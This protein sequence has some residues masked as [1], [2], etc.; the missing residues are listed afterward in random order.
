LVFSFVLD[1]GP[2][3]SIMEVSMW[4]QLQISQVFSRYWSDNSTS[5]TISYSKEEAKD[6]ERA[7]A[8]AIGNVKT[9]SFA[10]KS[11]IK[12]AQAPVEAITYEKYVELKNQIGD[13]D[14]TEYRNSFASGGE[15]VMY[16][17][18]DK[19]SI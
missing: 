19:C 15:G 16:C 1:Q 8:Y 2:I 14:F 4:E 5:V 11:D 7:I 18:G 6:L 10:P 9:L 12:Y 17:D 13:L 3:R